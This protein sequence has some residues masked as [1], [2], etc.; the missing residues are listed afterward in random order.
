[1]ITGKYG[2]PNIW[3][4]ILLQEI[5]FLQIAD[6]KIA[7]INLI[8]QKRMTKN[9]LRAARKLNGLSQERVALYMGMKNSA[10]IET[11]EQGDAVPNLVQLLSLGIIYSMLVTDLY[12]ALYKKAAKEIGLKL[13]QLYKQKSKPKRA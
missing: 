11:W 8:F 5:D 13:K 4:I 3:Y 10:V 1:L 7:F 6:Q 2:N 12:P 9:K